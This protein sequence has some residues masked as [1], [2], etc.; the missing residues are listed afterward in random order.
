MLASPVPDQQCLKGAPITLTVTF[1]GSDGEPADPGTVTIG[2]TKADGTTVVAAGTATTV[3]AT[4]VRTYALAASATTALELL[5]ATWTSSTH[6]VRTTLVEVAGGYWFTV[7]QARE[8]DEKLN[9][10]TK[11]SSARI[12]AVRSEVE[13]EAEDITSRAW[14]P[15]YR[16]ARVE[17]SGTCE[18]VLPDV[19][20]RS[21]RSVRVYESDNTTYTAFTAAELAAIEVTRWGTLIRRDGAWFT[22]GFTTVIEYEYGVDAPPPDLRDAA[23]TRLRHRLNAHRAGIPD[24]ATSMQ[25]DSGQTYNIATPGLRGFVTGIPDVDVVY[26]RYTFDEIGVA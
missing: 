26:G 22:R 18:L 3:G 20:L 13:H 25:T 21:V 14:V 1:G 17:G 15:R 10:T 23:I 11:Y 24:R 7:A 9:D 12:V 4:G 19:D 16:R 5:T 6:G 8:R 2:V